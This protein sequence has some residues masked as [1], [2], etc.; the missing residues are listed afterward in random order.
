LLL[1]IDEGVAVITLNRPEKLNAWTAAMEREL[2]RHLQ[3]VA[4]DEQV[5]AVV[6]TGAGRGFCAGADMD[7]L[8]DA[9]GGERM[10]RDGELP[11]DPR[12]RQSYGFPYGFLAL[13]PKPVVAAVNGTAVGLGLV[14]ALYADVRI[15]A[16]E[17]R[18]ATMFSRRGLIAEW[19]TAWIL[20]R[21]VGAGPAL[22]LLLSGRSFS[23]EE[24]VAMG[25]ATKAVEPAEVAT[26][27]IEYARELA[28]SC[29]PRSL[30]VIKRQTY[31]G[32]E[33]SL[34]EAVET[35]EEEMPGA[36]ESPDVREGIDSFLERRP[37][38]FPPLAP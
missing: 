1:E 20:P 21:L 29:S 28:A 6:I 13:L 19:G 10:A 15:V 23:G 38:R 8:S 7:L 11:G 37:P 27:A 14:I 16:S 30:A 33:Q 26:A 18:L 32:L 5:R 9:A 36:L 3:R 2:L 17:A 31:A 25:L 4:A 22:E 12:L 35:F 34:R 24:A